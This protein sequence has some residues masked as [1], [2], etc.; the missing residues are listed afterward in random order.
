MPTLTDKIPTLRKNNP[1]ERL[2]ALETRRLRLGKD[3]YPYK[4]DTDLLAYLALQNRIRT[5]TDRM[6]TP[7]TGDLPLGQDTYPKTGGV[8]LRQDT[9][10]EDRRPARRAGY[11]PFRQDPYP[12]DRIP[13]LETGNLP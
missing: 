4:Q 1:E 5:L 10:P 2:P 11:L 3:A 6:P 12:S 13:T 9:Y 7:E 8:L